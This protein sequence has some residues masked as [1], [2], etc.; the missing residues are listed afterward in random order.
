MDFLKAETFGPDTPW[1]A[2]HAAVRFTA[3]RRGSLRMAMTIMLC[4]RRLALTGFVSLRID[5]ENTLALLLPFLLLVVGLIILVV[6]GDV[7]VRG[8]SSV[9]RSLG[10]SPVVIGL[11]VV[12]FG[13]SAPELAVNISAAVDGAPDL[14]F[15]NIIGSNIANIGLIVGLTAIMR[16]LLIHKSIVTREIPMMLLA[17]AMA[18][19]NAYDMWLDGTPNIYSRNDGI[20]LLLIFG[21]F[22]YYTVSDVLRQ[23]A[24]KPDEV[25]EEF[26]DVA[27]SEPSYPVWKS[28]LFILVGLV[29]LVGGGKLTVYS[30]TVIAEAMG[31]PPVIIGLILVAVGTS[32]PELAT[33]VVAT[34]KGQTDIA[35]GNVVGSN[36]FNLLFVQGV[37]STIAPTPIPHG[38]HFDL[39][40]MVLLSV[41][42]FPL[43]I[44]HQRR[45][46]RIEGV[47][48]L[49]F[50]ICYVVWRYTGL[51]QDVV[52]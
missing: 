35:V 34:L 41:I 19:V 30:A 26:G 32:L 4:L 31:V 42:L 7:L 17:S 40:A 27:E 25:M 1:Y 50:Y 9:A 28:V 14:S 18:F 48:L 46:V 43:A 37:S 21:V 52:T 47:L 22:M 8:A 24:E 51:G 44:T 11:T 36:I 49:L 12:A 15:G 20:I 23:R 29:G 13:T 39:L 5:L 10:V 45:I 3:V 38:G 33:S 6:G 16:P 2:I